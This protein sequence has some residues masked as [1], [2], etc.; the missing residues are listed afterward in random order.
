MFNDAFF[1]SIR[2]SLF[3]GH[4][5]QAQIDSLN[6][7]EEAWATYG[8]GDQRKFAYILATAL[9]ESDRFKTMQEYASGAAYEGRHDLGN[10]VPGDGRRFKGRGFVQLTGRKNYAYWSHRLGDDLLASPDKVMN[11]AIAARILVEGMMLG[12]FTGKKLSAYINTN[13][14]AFIE[15]RRVVN[16]TDKASLIAGYATHFLAA[17]EAAASAPQ[18]APAVALQ[19]DVEAPYSPA[20]PGEPGYVP[21]SEKPSGVHPVAVTAGTVGFGAVVIGFAKWMG[22]I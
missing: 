1:A 22:W 20:L 11:R 17:L 14:Y 8:D 7:I 19:P 6:A 2:S 13:G 3:G 16:G 12:T 9:H 4:I 21:S 5:T 15:A 18:P 10:T